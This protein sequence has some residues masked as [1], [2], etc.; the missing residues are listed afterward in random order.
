MSYDIDEDE[1]KEILQKLEK[2]G[3]IEIDSNGLKLTKFGK[4]VV[5][6][7]IKTNTNEN[8]ERNKNSTYFI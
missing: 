8:N 2:L 5:E 3:L 6:S 7:M 1:L 4:E